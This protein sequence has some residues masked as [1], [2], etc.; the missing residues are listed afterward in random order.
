LKTEGRIDVTGR[1]GRSCKQL[2]DDL[3][4]RK[5]YRKLK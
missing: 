2:L 3:K 1:Q 4:D 5:I